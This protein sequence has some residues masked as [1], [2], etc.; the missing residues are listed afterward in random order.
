MHDVVIFGAG[1]LGRMVCDILRLDPD[2]RVAGFLDSDAR[3]HGREIE[4]APVLGGLERIATLR[5]AEVVAIGENGARVRIAERIRKLGGRLRKAVHPLATLAPSANV[6]EHV[7]IGA[8]ATVC[9]H[10]SVADH[11]VLSA[12][13]IVEHDNRLGVG[14]FLD[15]AVRLA[16]GVEVGAQARLGIGSCV[17]PYRKVGAF[18]QVEPGSVVIRDVYRGARVGGA[19]ARLIPGPADGFVADRA[20]LAP[21]P[22]R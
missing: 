10:A 4:G 5:G 21:V 9:V 13:T 1:G 14:V 17:I 8:R 6:A 20:N 11:C 2:A 7:I 12:G 18:A 16:G 15:P 22:A 19:P 3:L